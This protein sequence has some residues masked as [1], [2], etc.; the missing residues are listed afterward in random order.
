MNKQLFLSLI[1]VVICFL[2]ACN[3]QPAG[4][5][6]NEY[7]V[8]KQTYTFAI[9]GADTL[10][11]DKYEL[12][13]IS[14]G[15]T[16]SKPVILFAF[17]GG[18]KGG[19]RDND[20]YIPYFHFLAKNGYVVVSTDYRTGLKDIDTGKMA[21]PMQFAATLQKAI[22]M[23]V[24]DFFDAT[25]YIVD[26][27]KEWKVNP[28]QIVACGSSAGA[29]TSLQAEYEIC[30]R[31]PLTQKLPDSF[32]YAGVISFAGAICSL[33]IPDWQELPCP[34]ML[35][36]GNADRTVPFDKALLENMGLWGSNFIVKQLQVKQSPYY[37]YLAEE[38]GHEMAG[39]PMDNNRYDILSFLDR[40]VLL[41]Q[42]AFINTIETTPGKPETKKDFT[43]Q[44]YIQ[45]NL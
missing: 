37:F 24:E 39:I 44:D 23:A 16:L 8:G 19:N 38:A 18:F 22:A 30:N 35:F 7:I 3:R 10:R 6:T 9:K 1:T 27:S 13:N 33:G 29:V 36:H 43:L 31:T 41:R 4:S 25:R 15:D 45:N 26:N 17:G 42:K 5:R 14:A 21:D 2:T 11:L 12:Q 28:E 40:F 32:N 34:I 20:S